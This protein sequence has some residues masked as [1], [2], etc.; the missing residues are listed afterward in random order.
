VLLLLLLVVCAQDGDLMVHFPGGMKTAIANMSSSWLQSVPV[1]PSNRPDAATKP[2][3]F[4][5]TRAASCTAAG[6]TTATTGSTAPKAG[7]TTATTGSSAQTA[8]KL[9]HITLHSD[10]YNKESQMKKEFEL[11]IQPQAQGFSNWG[12]PIAP[13]PDQFAAVLQQQL[14]QRQEQQQLQQ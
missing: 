13:Q 4:T 2:A 10:L 5:I 8:G 1:V 3:L 9:V 11:C 7:G 14:Q 6:S 12:W